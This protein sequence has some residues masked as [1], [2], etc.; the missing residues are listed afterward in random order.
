[1]TRLALFFLGTLALASS[2]ACAHFQAAPR[3]LYPG[4][5]RP[6][7]E[8][9]RLSGPVARVDDVNVSHHGSAFA[10]L[11]G[12][13]VVVLKRNVGE[14]GVGGAWSADLGLVVYVFR[15]KAGNSYEIELHT[16]P[17]NG[18]VGNA[19]VGGVKVKAFERDG[20]GKALA[21]V[22]PVRKE[23]EVEACREAD[24]PAQSQ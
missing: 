2:G 21:T 9:A 15:M 4:P 16:Q 20:R 6:A 8:V 3:S 11:P 14:G 1:M 12:C 19:N 5:E 13:H 22:E 24:R 23:D 17:G 7:A 10:L 18:G